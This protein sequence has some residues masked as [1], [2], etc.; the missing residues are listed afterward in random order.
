[1]TTTLSSRTARHSLSVLR[2]ALS[3]E[4]TKQVGQLSRRAFVEYRDPHRDETVSMLGAL[5]GDLP[6]S[7]RITL[8]R[9]RLAQ[10]ACGLVLLR[11]VAAVENLGETPASW[12]AADT[13]ESRQYAF[14][15]LLLGSLFG[16]PIGWS[17]QQSGRVVT[18]VLPSRGSE[19]TF[20]SASSS[21][22]L[23]WHTEDGFSP[24]RAD[25]LGLL[26]LR[27]PDRVPTTVSQVAV[28]HL[29]G[30]T[31]EVL[32]EGRFF[33]ARD[34]AHDTGM[35]CGQEDVPLSILSGPSH[36]PTLRADRDFMR[37]AAGDHEAAVAL[38]HLIDHL[39][40]RL[41]DV[42]LEPGD[43]AFINNNVAVH[44]RRSF[45]ASYSPTERWLK[46]INVVRDI[47]RTVPSHADGNRR[48]IRS[49]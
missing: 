39:D 49:L 24:Y 29:P 37:P 41:T 35:A 11:N 13:A 19:Q 27:N 45:R 36:A 48:I 40:E 9:A 44:G 42:V 18:D 1:M 15:A 12:R 32:R 25:W 38:A 14:T 28:D 2:Y 43:M 46:R 33:I 30:R 34:P 31:E 3:A 20:V 47:R 22:E 8:Q 5:A 6:L 26:C 21:R 17:A 7:V 10:N 4:E 16:D 23:A